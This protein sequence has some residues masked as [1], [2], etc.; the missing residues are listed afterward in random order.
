MLF[1][2]LWMNL[3][4]QPPSGLW[5][6]QHPEFSGRHQRSRGGSGVGPGPVLCPCGMGTDPARESA[7]PA[8]GVCASL[9]STAAIFGLEQGEIR[10]SALVIK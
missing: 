6:L 8:R 7:L 4:P 10:E 9:A 3:P 2:G 1:L 5:G